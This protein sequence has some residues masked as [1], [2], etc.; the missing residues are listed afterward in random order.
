MGYDLA[1]VATLLALG[2]IFFGHFEER[3]PKWRKVLKLFVTLGITALLSRSFGH[4]GV[5]I[6]FGIA[7]LPVIFIHAWWLPKKHGVNGWTG[8]PRDRY[9]ELRGWKR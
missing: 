6:A 3:T 9:Y 1:A 5:A 8:E 4:T 7:L 2:H